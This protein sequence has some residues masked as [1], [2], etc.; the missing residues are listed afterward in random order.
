M[1][2]FFRPLIFLLVLSLLSTAPA[3]AVRYVDAGDT[4]NLEAPACFSLDDLE[5]FQIERNESGV[6][7]EMTFLAERD[8]LEGMGKLYGCEI[9]KNPRLKYSRHG[10]RDWDRMYLVS[11][12][13]RQRDGTF[14]TLL[15]MLDRNVTEAVYFKLR[16]VI[17]PSMELLQVSDYVSNLQREYGPN[18]LFI[19]VFDYSARS[20]LGLFDLSGRLLVSRGQA[21]RPQPVRINSHPQ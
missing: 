2:S 3:L 20:Y 8:L 13:N 1:P 12:R 11:L 18:E 9:I 6:W 17:F 19:E 7:V 4:N 5:R 14:R 15:S 10:L 21:V 16:P